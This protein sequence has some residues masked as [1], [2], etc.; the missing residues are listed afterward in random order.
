MRS[1]MD[2]KSGIT[3]ELWGDDPLGIEIDALPVTAGE[4]VQAHGTTGGGGMDEAAITDIDPGMT[5]GAATIGG[6]E[7]Q[8]TTFQGVAT[9]IRGAHGAQLTRRTRQTDTGSIA[10]NVAD[11]A[12]AVETTFGVLPP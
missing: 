11:Q 6:K 10:I 3:R 7:H 5:D 1:T 8:V 4:A 12:T 9:D 2:S